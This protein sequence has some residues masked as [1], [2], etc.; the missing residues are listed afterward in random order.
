MGTS[1]LALLY[2]RVVFATLITFGTTNVANWFTSN[3]AFGELLN[4]METSQR[5]I[6]MIIV[7][8]VVIATTF[9]D[10]ALVKIRHQR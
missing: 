4:K 10:A 8:W 9:I 5:L 1:W 6:F 2:T 3:C 7:L